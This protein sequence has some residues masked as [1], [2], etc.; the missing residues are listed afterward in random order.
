MTKLIALAVGMTGTF[1]T[2]GQSAGQSAEITRVWSETCVNIK[3]TSGAGFGAPDPTSVFVPPLGTPATL[4]PAG[5]YFLP[6][7]FVAATLAELAKGPVTIVPDTDPLSFGARAVGLTFNPSQ[8]SAVYK[9]KAGYAS[10]IDQLEARRQSTTD[11]EAKRL[12][13][14]A[15]N[16][17]QTAQMW[18]VKAL[19][20]AS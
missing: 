10:L 15:I 2:N 1:Y 18:A 19:T 12:C 6:D 5:Y 4:H 17:A 20:W 8:D 13:S 9:C 16:E 7:D 3:I 14:I 11:G